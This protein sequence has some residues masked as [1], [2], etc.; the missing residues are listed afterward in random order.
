MTDQFKK[1]SVK[2]HSSGFI[3]KDN[4]T[5]IDEWKHSWPEVEI[6]YRLNNFSGDLNTKFQIRAV[7]VALRVWQWRIS[8]LKF[9]RERNPDA[10]VDFNVSF[11]D[12][13]HFDGK[14]QP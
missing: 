7:T 5:E 11:E 14:K 8:K 12:L 2:A 13:A 10:H 1:C 3:F 6:S 9:R 4:I